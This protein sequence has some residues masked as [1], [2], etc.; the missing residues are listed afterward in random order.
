[1]SE[2]NMEANGIVAVDFETYY[3][4]EY[5]L[6][7]TSTWNY[8]HS[9]RFDAYL[10]A[11]H[12][13][14]VHFVGHPSKADWSA[15]H[16]KTVVMHNASFDEL[17][18]ARLVEMGVV[19]ADVKPAEVICT[20]DMS[21]YLGCKRDLKTAARE[22]LGK[23]VSKEVRAN[24]K[25]RTYA[26]A[27][28]AGTEDA[29]LAYGSSDAELCYELA[30]KHLASWPECERRVSALNRAAGVKGVMLDIDKVDAG[31]RSL[32]TRLADITTALPWVDEGKPPLSV[33]AI[34][35]EGRRAGIPV[36]ASLAK[37]SPEVLQWRADYG[38]AH[39]WVEATGEYRSVNTLLKRV[40]NL[41]NGARADRTMPYQIKYWGANTGR[42]SGGGDSGCKFNMQNMP[43]HDMFGV[44]VRSMFVP[45][46]GKKFVIAD[47]AQI[48]ARLLLWR[49]G[50]HDFIELIKEEGNL[51]I[52]YAKRRGRV[53]AK[54]TPEY[55]LAKCQVLQL[56]YYCGWERFM[57]TANKPPYLLDL[58][59]ED[60]KAAVYEY[61]DANP[62]VVRHWYEH[63]K[64]LQISTTHGDPTHEVALPSGRVIRYHRPK[65]EVV[66]DTKRQKKVVEFSALG[67]LGG[68]RTRLHA[69]IL[70][71]NEIQGM[72]RDV[73]RDAWLALD[74][75]GYHDVLW[76]VHDEVIVE[77]DEAAAQDAC[78]RIVQIMRSASPWAAGCP[79][80]AEAIVADR[81]CK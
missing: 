39:P 40:E 42:F 4:D 53:I 51:Y 48:E 69:G 27:V 26:D 20:A 57:D 79:L 15:L 38:P 23:D 49:V 1:M 62:L 10:V 45:R 77:V 35:E 19:P 6:S 44:D 36:P 41:R 11:I 65:S 52:A 74:D 60:A 7:K 46:P 32:K 12:G 9:P 76:T 13:E 64:W 50:D 33:A 8:V 56:G 3:D 31:L 21:A 28:L 47:F 58:S 43:Q 61:R 63:Q 55:R 16:G 67:E 2:A 30:A 80:D 70:T 14:G 22:L 78:D 18:L 5:S 37:D 73:L 72:A 24:M 59:P 66:F 34:R 25:G 54:G 29:L 68:P 75:A 71:N 17:V 81:Y